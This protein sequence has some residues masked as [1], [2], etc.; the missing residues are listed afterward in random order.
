[1]ARG[2]WKKRLDSGGQPELDPDP[3]IFKG[4]LTVQYWQWQRLLI[5]G[6][7]RVRICA[8]LRLNELQRLSWRGLRSPSAFYSGLYMYDSCTQLEKKLRFYYPQK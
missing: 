2:P 7:E 3:G 8:D 6:F 1:M 4:I 5:L